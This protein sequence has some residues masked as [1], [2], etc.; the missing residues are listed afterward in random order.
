MEERERERERACLCVCCNYCN[1]VHSRTPPEWSDAIL[2]TFIGELGKRFTLFSEPHILPTIF[3]IGKSSKH[4]RQRRQA[5]QARQGWC[6]LKKMDVT[7]VPGARSVVIQRNAAGKLGIGFYQDVA[8]GTAGTV[9]S[10]LRATLQNVTRLERS[11]IV[12]SS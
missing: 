9:Q 2:G 6:V 4:E 12:A 10:C 3:K 5:R 7:Q 1:Q 8:E 11:S